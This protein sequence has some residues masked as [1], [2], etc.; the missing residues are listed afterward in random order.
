MQ[1]VASSHSR[2]NPSSRADRADDGKFHAEASLY[3]Y[4]ARYYDPSAGRFI[5]EDP[6]RFRGSYNFFEYVGNS[7]PAFMDPLG[8][9]R[10]EM[11][12][13]QLGGAKLYSHTYLLVTGPDTNG[14]SLYFR[15]GPEHGARSSGSGGYGNLIGTTGVYGPTTKDWDT[16]GTDLSVPLLDDGKPCACVVGKLAGF[17]DRVNA[18]RISYAAETTNSNAFSFG[19]ARAAGLN[20]GSPY[21]SAPGYDTNLPLP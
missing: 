5:A 12:Y 6:L 2:L 4:R 10:V 17:T 11:H 15:G 21:I 19:A 3:Y 18:S 13:Q 9:C 8:L 1:H 14:Y 16:N 7:P 20:P